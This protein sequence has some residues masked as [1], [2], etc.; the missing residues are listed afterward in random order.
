M[1][2]LA[3][4]KPGA[5]DATGKPINF[6]LVDVEVAPD[7]SLY[8]SDHNQGV[9]RIYY[10]EAKS[11]PS[12]PTAAAAALVNA[13]TRPPFN[14]LLVEVLALPQIGSEWSRNREER[15]RNLMAQEMF[16]RHA[17]GPLED[18][19]REVAL[20]RSQAMDKRLRAIRLLAANFAELP[21]VFVNRLSKDA[22]PE[23]RAQA[24][25]L[26][27]LRSGRGEIPAMIRRPAYGGGE[28]A[29]FGRND[30]VP[31]LT[32]LLDD[33]D[34]FVRRRAAEA[35]T[36]FRQSEGHRELVQHL[37]D[38]VRAVRNAAKIA[39]SRP[40]TFRDNLSVSPTEFLDLQE[41]LDS[42]LTEPNT[43]KWIQCWRL[44]I[45]SQQRLLGQ[46]AWM[47][48]TR[49]GL[50]LGSRRKV[51]SRKTTNWTS[52]EFLAFTVSCSRRTT[53]IGSESPNI[54]WRASPPA[55]PTS[56]SSRSA[57]SANIA[58]PKPSR[59][60][61][62]NLNASATK[63]RSSTSR[64]PSAGC[65]AVGRRSRRSVCSG[66]CSARSAAGSRSSRAKASNSR[67]SCPPCW[68]TSASITA[69]PSCAH[70]RRSS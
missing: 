25:W 11:L 50:S 40:A 63:S 45:R 3:K 46:V 22:N 17:G 26:L 12:A 1:E 33:Q 41:F 21:Q 66:G 39:V 38:P 54:P 20:S 15:I 56:A 18:R 67:C 64:R 43:R 29:R 23:I 44:R 49:F 31:S 55:T 9:W 62:T 69:P 32:A 10:S 14:Q 27:G 57:C 68:P 6:A 59:S 47:K 60:C 30:E 52:C 19:L 35:L 8:V 58:S 36:R 24:A 51:S 28:G 5:R 61:S 42:T 70:C 65:R 2:V 13:P 48:R 34:P 37:S 53:R 16:K 4:P 7:G